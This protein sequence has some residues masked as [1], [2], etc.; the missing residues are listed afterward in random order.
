MK[1]LTRLIE[2]I[3][4]IF[5]FGFFASSPS[6]LFLT[7]LLTP[8]LFFCSMKQESVI[9]QESMIK[10]EIDQSPINILI[11]LYSYPTWYNPETYLWTKIAKSATQIPITAVINPNNGPDGGPPNKDYVR[12]LEDLRT[13]GVTIFG[14][15]ATNYG[16]RS[17]T[18]VKSDIDLY[19]KYYNIKG[20]FLD[21]AASNE[22][23]LNYYQ[24]IYQ[25]IKNK[26]NLYTVVLNQGT[27]TDEG[28]LSLPA[29]DISVIFENYSQPWLGYESKPY[30]N[31]YDR[32]RFSILIHTVPDIATMKS[33]IDL[34]LK[35]NI[36]YIYITD[37]SPD[38]PDQDPWNSLPSYWEAEVNYLQEVFSK[39]K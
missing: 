17:L 27:Q 29:T 18:E 21:E 34:A 8:S 30:L 14:Y 12:G 36:G 19:H 9:K 3:K 20:I 31:K 26:S 37:D 2:N 28:Y 39:R 22:N 16:N 10:Q 32:K 13:A 4:E 24:E 11:P 5:S 6:R 35:R 38:S 1:K 15:V 23:K 25:Y 7:I 33:H